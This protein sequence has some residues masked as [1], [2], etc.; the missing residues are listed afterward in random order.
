MKFKIGIIIQM[1]T[2]ST[3]LTN[4]V[5]LP[6]IDDDLLIDVILKKFTVINEK[7]PVIIATTLNLKDNIIVEYANKYNFS[8]Y[9]GS[10]EDVL[11]RFIDAANYFKIDVIIRVCGDNPFLSIDYIK[12]LINEFLKNP[13]L[14][15]ISYQN[16]NG[17]PTIRTHYGFFAELVK[18]TALK[19]ITENTQEKF[20]HE[21]VTNYIYEHTKKFS[22]HLLDIPFD[23]NDSVRLTVDTLEDLNLSKEIYRYFK[24]FKKDLSPEIVMSYLN[25][26]SY[27]LDEM[28]I[29][30]QKQ[31]K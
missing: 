11:T 18:L 9:R 14:D 19:K 4:K 17:I 16:K 2:S 8:V 7:I 3:R 5:L 27:Y 29:Q 15:Y 21:H 28:A 12:N 6:F 22:V 26:N 30:I 20:Y 24:E 25:E 23:E 31:I 13:D 1:R 10:E